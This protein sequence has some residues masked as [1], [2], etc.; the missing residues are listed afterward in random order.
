MLMHCTQVGTFIVHSCRNWKKKKCMK[1]DVE[2]ESEDETTPDSI[3]AEQPLP[4]LVTKEGKD[5]NSEQ[6]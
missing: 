1:A 5:S 6:C 2:S 3:E 4:Q